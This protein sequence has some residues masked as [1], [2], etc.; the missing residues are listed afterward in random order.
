MFFGTS[1]QKKK[2]LTIEHFVLLLRGATDS[3]E[4]SSK[5][6]GDIVGITLGHITKEKKLKNEMHWHVQEVIVTEQELGNK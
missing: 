3:F 5:L 2:N 1:I 4:F 6:L